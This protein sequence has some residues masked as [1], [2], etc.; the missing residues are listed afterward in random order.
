MSQRIRL[1]W[2]ALQRKGTENGLDS[3]CHGFRWWMVRGGPCGSRVEEEEGPQGPSLMANNEAQH[4]CVIDT[5]I[6]LRH[7]SVSVFQW[8]GG[9]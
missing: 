2:G 7:D 4:G 5:L 3:P 9:L 8:L 6:A 1:A